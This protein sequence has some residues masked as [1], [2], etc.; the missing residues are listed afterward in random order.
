[1][2]ISKF[3]SAVVGPLRSRKVRVAMATVLAAY[4]AE[5]R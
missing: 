4:A 1:M 3:V 5:L 2:W